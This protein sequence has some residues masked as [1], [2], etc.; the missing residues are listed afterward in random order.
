MSGPQRPLVP[1][2]RP[3]GSPPS[4]PLPPS[5]AELIAASRSAYSALYER[6]AAAARCLARQLVHGRAE[7]DDLVSEAFARVLGRL[8]RGG[9]PDSAFRPYL[10]TTVRRV[11]YDRFK[12]EGKVVVSGE[13][14]AFDSGVPF[15]DPAVADLER[16]MIVRAFASLPER[17]RTVL[18]HTEI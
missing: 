7:S 4:G 3:A 11:A 15:T 12:A 13:M 18:W 16:T 8:R 5:D 9:G 14:E 10:L 6:H 17:W 1:G 2:P